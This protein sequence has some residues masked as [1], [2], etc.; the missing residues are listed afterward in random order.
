MT[1]TIFLKTANRAA[2]TLVA[3]ISDVAVSLTLQAGEGAEFPSTFPFRI[4]SDDEILQVEGRS[5]DV[6]SSLS[7]GEEGTSPAAHLAGAN[8]R[9]HITAEAMSEIHSAINDLEGDQTESLALVTKTVAYTA[10][11]SDTV[12]LCDAAAGTFTVTLPTA[13]G[14]AG[15]VF[16][17]KKIDATVN[18]VTVAGDGAE[19]IDGENT[20]VISTQY[21]AL[22]L[23]SDG[24]EWHIL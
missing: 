13:V 4:T 3:G 16:Y 19:T 10:T 6:L 20:Q 14:R 15:K 17:I 9:L 18:A 24:S 22:K 1:A 5:G 2:G 8:V 11:D 7:R 21:N 23:I 12:I